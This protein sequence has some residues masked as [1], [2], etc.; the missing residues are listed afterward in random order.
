[1]VAGGETAIRTP[2]LP[3][4]TFG[5]MRQESSP[6]YDEDAVPRVSSLLY[7]AFRSAGHALPHINDDNH[8]NRVATPNRYWTQSISDSLTAD[9]AQGYDMYVRPS[10]WSAASLAAAAGGRNAYNSAAYSP[11]YSLDSKQR[12]YAASG[13]SSLALPSLPLSAYE[14]GHKPQAINTPQNR[15][16]IATYMTPTMYD[17]TCWY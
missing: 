5:G 7:N 17:S 12:S 4:Y 6:S 11:D 16:G 10:A 8:Y 14:L 1:M 3:G 9:F 15:P 2:Q 13:Q